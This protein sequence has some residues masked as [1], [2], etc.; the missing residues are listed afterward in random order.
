MEATR[1]NFEIADQILTLLAKENCT[2][3]EATE[4]LAYVSCQVRAKSTVQYRKGE[5]IEAA[6]LVN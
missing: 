3:L 4:I 6:N 1:K 5:L 2:V